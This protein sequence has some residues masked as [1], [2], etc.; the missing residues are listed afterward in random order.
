MSTRFD[1]IHGTLGA[2]E[3]RSAPSLVVG[4]E[5]HE[6]EDALDVVLSE[7]GLE[8]AFGGAAAHEALRA[9]AGVDAGGL[10]ADDAARPLGRRGRDADQRHHLLRRQPRDGRLAPDRPQRADR[11][12]GPQRFLPVD[13]AAGDVLGEHLDEQ[14][15]LEDHRVD[16]LVEELGEA[17]HVDAL[18]VGGQVDGAVDRR[19]HHRLRL[20]AGDAHGLRDAG[21]A[22]A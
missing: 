4:C 11:H 10:H 20:L 5:R 14:R 17:R 22:G 13:D 6:L 9:R 16:R 19:G 8:Q 1:G 15:L 21:D 3:Q 7:A 2:D 12:L 18:L